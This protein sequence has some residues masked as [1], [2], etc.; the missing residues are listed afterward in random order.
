MR[1]IG[2]S[3]GIRWESTVGYYQEI[4][5]GIKKRLGGS[6]PLR[7]YSLASILISS[8]NCSTAGIGKPLAKSLVMRRGAWGGLGV[9]PQ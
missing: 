4:N 1:T 6:I 9:G 7:S 5:E 3:G 8:K 2:L